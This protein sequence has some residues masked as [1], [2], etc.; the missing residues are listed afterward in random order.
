VP[1]IKQMPCQFLRFL[2]NQGFAAMRRDREGRKKPG[3]RYL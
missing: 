3:F 1:E 2:L